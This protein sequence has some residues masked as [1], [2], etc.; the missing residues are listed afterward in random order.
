MTSDIKDLTDSTFEMMYYLHMSSEE[1]DRLTTYEMREYFELLKE[2]VKKET[3]RDSSI[4]TSIAK[5]FG[6]KK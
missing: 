3:E 5:V 4:F 1:V 2:R 6:L